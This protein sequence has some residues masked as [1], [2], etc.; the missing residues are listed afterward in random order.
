MIQL[1]LFTISIYI[2]YKLYKLLKCPK[3]LIDVPSLGLL[4][5]LKIGASKDSFDDMI[6]KELG[7]MLEKHGVVRVFKFIQSTIILV[8]I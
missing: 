4:A 5:A 7:P 6:E 2:C 1:V 8:N 3:E